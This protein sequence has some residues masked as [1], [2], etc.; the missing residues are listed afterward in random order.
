MAEIEPTLGYGNGATSLYE[1][2]PR[3]RVGSS[4]GPKEQRGGAGRICRRLFGGRET[5]PDLVLCAGGGGHLFSQPPPGAPKLGDTGRGQPSRT[6]LAPRAP[7][8]ARHRC[9]GRRP[10][11]KKKTKNPPL[12][13]ATV[14]K[15]HHAE[16]FAALRVG[17]VDGG[18]V[19]RPWG[20]VRRHHQQRGILPEPGRR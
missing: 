10:F 2:F 1:P 15:K 19:A 4:D 12:K 18:R 13:V 16:G 6:W 5:L 20:N 17:D 3:Q 9:A 14:G 7:A 8:C 11:S